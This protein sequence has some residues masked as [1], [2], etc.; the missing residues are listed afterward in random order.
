MSTPAEIPFKVLIADDAEEARRSVSMML[1]LVPDAQL[2]AEAENGRQAVE[3]TRRYN[4]EIIFLDINMPDMD[5]LTTLETLKAWNPNLVCVMIS[6][7]RESRT[8]RRA[9]QLGA[10]GYLVKPFTADEMLNAFARV[11]KMVSANRKK[12]GEQ[13]LMRA[14]RMIERKH[15][16]IQII[17]QR[18]YDDEA[19]LVFQELALDPLCDLRWLMH[20]AV[21]YTL[22]RDWS[23]LKQLAERLEQQDTTSPRPKP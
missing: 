4:P 9:L 11:S 1:S 5:G 17:Q 21:I 8:L 18:R 3:L 2:I 10:D 7:E 23:R 14:Q 22:R 12:A 6:A 15:Q 13:T 19:V 20:L 16:A